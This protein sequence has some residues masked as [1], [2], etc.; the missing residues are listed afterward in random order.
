[1]T[2]V[3]IIKY[4]LL[5][6]IVLFYLVYTLRY[7]ITFKK[8]IIFTGRRKIFH[9]ILIWIFPFVWIWILKFFLK[10]TPGSSEFLDKK[11]QINLKITQPIGL[12]LQHQMIHRRI[13]ISSHNKL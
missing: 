12:Y 11:T 9:S 5:A 4:T 2:T 10:P 6:A 8:N 13:K 7:A 3:Q 1:M